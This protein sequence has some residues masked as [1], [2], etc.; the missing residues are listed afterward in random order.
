MKNI[1]LVLSGGGARGI[2]HIGVIDELIR[3]G[4]TINS[5]AGTSMGAMVGGIYALGKMDDFKEW[6]FTIDRKEIFNLLDFSFSTQ[7]LVKG[8]KILNTMRE[9]I[10]DSN[11]EELKIPFT[12]TAVD[13]LSGEEIVFTSGSVYEAIRASIAIPI[14]FTPLKTNNHLLVDG[15]I[16]NNVP[17]NN[18]KRIKGDILVVVNVNAH[19][20]K[21]IIDK[22]KAELVKKESIYQKKLKGFQNQLKS[23]KW[24]N[25]GDLG[26]FKL[27]D[28][29]LSIMMHQMAQ[30]SLNHYTPDMLINISKD[31]CG[32][33]DFFKAE[34]M[35]EIGK[36]TT[37][38]AIRNYR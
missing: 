15:G 20:P 3:E 25:K 29:T 9:F 28:R 10:E 21:I 22:P 37:Q 8:D 31:S 35:I 36:V 32:T 7:G 13:L 17:I 34:E 23:L 4:F 5:I 6:L 2:A 30:H 19:I 11:I 33:Y 16:I 27:M 18:V 26:Y 12:A 14:V 38:R 1:A 24:F